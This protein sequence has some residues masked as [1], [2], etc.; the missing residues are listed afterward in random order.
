MECV[1]LIALLEL[2]LHGFGLGVNASE[3]MPLYIWLWLMCSVG[4]QNKVFLW[5]KSSTPHVLNS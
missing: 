1:L 4:T 2:L 3:E 5:L